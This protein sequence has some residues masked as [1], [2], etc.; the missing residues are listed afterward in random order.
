[1]S[2]SSLA[3]LAAVASTADAVMSHS[4]LVVVAAAERHSGDTRLAGNQ[5][6]DTHPGTHPRSSG[7][8]RP[9]RVQLEEV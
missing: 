1:M 8:K 3:G 2:D 7:T 5:S 4:D 9:K 6:E